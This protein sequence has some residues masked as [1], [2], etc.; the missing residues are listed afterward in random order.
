[1]YHLFLPSYTLFII[2]SSFVLGKADSTGGLLLFGALFIASI[3]LKREAAATQY[4]QVLALVGFHWFSELNWCHILYLTLIAK[5]LLVTRRGP[6]PLLAI[7]FLYTSI[8]TII[9][10]TYTGI[11]PYNLLVMGSAFVSAIGCNMNVMSPI[12]LSRWIGIRSCNYS[13]ISSR[14]ASKPWSTT[15]R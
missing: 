9:R 10:F 5:E 2:V 6:W 13:S 3:Y 7:T 14:M 11:T 4:L 12:C 1:M 15:E 8:Y